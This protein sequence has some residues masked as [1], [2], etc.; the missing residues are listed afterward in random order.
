MVM[1]TTVKITSIKHEPLDRHQSVQ[2][3]RQ[4]ALNGKS[5]WCPCTS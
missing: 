1:E 5:W 4:S 3:V 2:T